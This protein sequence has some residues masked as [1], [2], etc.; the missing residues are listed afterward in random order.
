MH[1]CASVLSSIASSKFDLT[2]QIEMKFLNNA[3]GK[4]Y[5]SHFDINTAA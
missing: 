3:G 5:S 2:K 1:V 4:S